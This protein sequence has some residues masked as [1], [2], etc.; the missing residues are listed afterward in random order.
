VPVVVDV[1]GAAERLVLGD[2][3]TWVQASTGGS[4]SASCPKVSAPSAKA[5]S[6]AYT[7][8]SQIAAAAAKTTRNKADP[9]PGGRCAYRRRAEGHGLRWRLANFRGGVSGRLRARSTSP[10]ASMVV[11]EQLAFDRAADF[12]DSVARFGPAREATVAAPPRPDVVH[13][14]VVGDEVDIVRR[15]A[16]PR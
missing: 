5:P 9:H 12:L 3:I 14:A 4:P 8:G 11:N 7:I 16:E 6:A 10:S 13:V 15:I 1:G 2:F